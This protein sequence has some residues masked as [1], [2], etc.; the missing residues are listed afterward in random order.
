M[1][2]ATLANWRQPPQN[3]WAFR[4]VDQIIATKKISAAAPAPLDRGEMLDIAAVQFT[5]EGR[6]WSCGGVLEETDGDGLLVLK[7]GKVVHEGYRHGD[8]AARHILFS[9]SK[10]ITGILAGILAGDGKLDVEAPVTRY[11]PEV[12]NS[13]YGSATVRQVLDMTVN[14]TF[15]EDY[16]DTQSAFA[17]YRVA[18]GWNPPNPEF[19]ENGLHSF[20]GTL[21][22]ASGPHGQVFHYVS[23]NS[24]L[25]GWILERADSGDVAVQLARRIWQPMG[26]ES[27]AYVTVDRFGAA[28]TAGGICTTLRDLA[29]FGEM[30]RCGGKANGRQIVPKAW[31]DDMWRNGDATAWQG[32]TMVELFPRGRY[33]SQW[34][35]TD[36]KSP[37]L[38]AIGIHGQW[39]FVDQGSELTIVKQSSQKQ[40]LDYRIDRLNFALFQAISRCW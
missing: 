27:E 23:P 24:D 21:P 33:R 1:T 38:C 28:R 7:G 36:E 13:A 3:I 25:L 11:V 18:T 29:R 34:Y 12:E 17:R 6:Q 5:F 19:S 4:H 37:A 26:A 22:K 16:L 39:I 31:I 30:I 35:V 10:S 8:A 14:V 9:V 15:D 32:G 2:R 40:P 20:L